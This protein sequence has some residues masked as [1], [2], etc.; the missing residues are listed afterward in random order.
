MKAIADFLQPDLRNQTLVSV[1]ADGRVRPTTAED[2]YLSLLRLEL[3]PKVP[4]NVRKLFDVCRDLMLYAWFVYEFYTVAAHQALVCLEFALRE[5]HPV[6]Q[7]DKKGRVRH[8]GLRA[9][10]EHVKEL[11]YFEQDARIAEVL[12]SIPYIRNGEAHGSDTVL[13]FALA[14]G[15]LMQV[16]SIINTVYEQEPS[17]RGKGVAT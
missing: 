10:L 11:G 15:V 16:R 2:G 9:H 14:E 13:N 5:K 1:D 12:E 4:E 7:T 3:S 17:T 6:T 8:Q